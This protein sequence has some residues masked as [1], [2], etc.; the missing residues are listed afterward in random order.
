MWV[1]RLYDNS[2]RRNKKLLGEKYY[3]H[4]RFHLP[5]GTHRATP[6]F[7]ETLALEPGEYWLYTG[8]LAVPSGYDL[9]KVTPGKNP[10][11]A[12]GGGGGTTFTIA[13]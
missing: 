8:L 2:D 13:D 10:G 7:S 5:W 4:K 9:T 11:A 12:S 6:A 1:I 3:L